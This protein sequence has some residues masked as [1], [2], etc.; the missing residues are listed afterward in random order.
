M[1]YYSCIAAPTLIDGIYYNLNT[2][3][4]TASV[5]YNNIYD[6]SYYPMKMDYTRFVI[7]PSKVKH[8]NIDYTVT[9][10][11]DSAFYRN[12]EI[13]DI[14]IPQSIT[15]IGKYALGGGVA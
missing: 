4:Q 2:S 13:T 12:W 15:S 3:D 7:I 5:T 11:G 8:N 10:I 1:S 9:A 14:S 6:E